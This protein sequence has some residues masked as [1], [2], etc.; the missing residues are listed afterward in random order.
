[1][2]DRKPKVKKQSVEATISQVL[3]NGTRTVT[4]KGFNNYF[5]TIDVKEAE[6]LYKALDHI[7]RRN[8]L[9]VTGI[10]ITLGEEDR[11]EIRGTT[12]YWKMMNDL[13][14]NMG[15]MI[16]AD[17]KEDGRAGEPGNG[18]K[19][20]IQKYSDAV[21]AAEIDTAKVETKGG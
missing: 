5:R 11:P 20:H 8:H 7:F 18:K 3:Q 6:L 1:M 14:E 9:G 21:K 16:P 15:T 10:K 12:A 4:M 2:A 19:L 17:V 13:A